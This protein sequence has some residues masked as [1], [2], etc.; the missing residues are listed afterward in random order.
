M[1]LGMRLS[2]SF[3][4][5]LALL[6]VVAVLAIAQLNLMIQTS[7][8]VIEG[9]NRRVELAQGIRQASEGAIGRLALLL[10]FEER[11]WRVRTYQEIDSLQ[12]SIDASLQQLEPLLDDTVSREQLQRLQTARGNYEA[13]F[14]AT[15]EDIES[16]DKASAL[17][18]MANGT[19]A[20]LEA[21]QQETRALV[22][23]QQAEIQALQSSALDRTAQ[24]KVWMVSLTIVGLLAVFVL[25]IGL[26]RSITRPMKIAL[27]TVRRVADG[28]LT[29]PVP[30]GGRDEWGQLLADLEG[31]RVSLAVLVR[32]IQSCVDKISTVGNEVGILSTAIELSIVVLA[33]GATHMAEEAVNTAHRAHLAHDLAQAG[34][35]E[36]QEAVGDIAKVAQA[37]ADSAT[38][39]EQLDQSTRLVSQS[40]GGIREIAQQINLLAINASVEA[41]RAGDSGRGFAV[42]AAEVR[43][44]AN[45]TAEATQQIHGL[46]AQI[47]SQTEHAVAAIEWGRSEMSR[48]GRRVND[49]VPPLRSL[50]DGA[51]AT[52]VGIQ[53]VQSIAL[54]QSGSARTIEQSVRG[55]ARLA[56]PDIHG[57][58]SVEY[59]S[60]LGMLLQSLLG[61]VRAF[62]I[63]E[64]R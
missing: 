25:A 47:V 62:R 36:I 30:Q 61:S 22:Q 16:G 27:D 39:V 34:V 40:V 29:S 12:A 5:V 14:T 11:E 33:Q 48:G 19:R 7:T 41:A 2:L 53:R 21:L 57:G 43:R 6:A 42:V 52:L 54:E 24:V 1:K 8:A 15:V 45:R 58:N 31:M 17:N 50:Q 9:G 59:S 3:G 60:S 4:S 63:E 32:E 18:R 26:T 28:D 35:N 20:A 49:L 23:S 46:I 55:I 37:V 38:S 51:Q 56:N 64:Q 13:A 10:V 44:L